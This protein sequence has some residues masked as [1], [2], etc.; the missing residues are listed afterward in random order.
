MFGLECAIFHEAIIL[1]LS[2]QLRLVLFTPDI[3]TII[4]SPVVEIDSSSDPNKITLYQEGN[5]KSCRFLY[6]RDET[7]DA[8]RN[9]VHLFARVL[10]AK[11]CAYVVDACCSDMFEACSRSC[12][13][14]LLRND[15]LNLRLQWSGQC[16]FATELMGGVC[17]WDGC[18]QSIHKLSKSTLY[19]FSSLASSVLPVIVSD[20][21]WTLPTTSDE[22]SRANKGLDAD[23]SVTMMNGNAILVSLL[24]G[25]IR[26]FTH[27]L[28]GENMKLQLPIVL[29][30]LLERASP[31][32]NHSVVQ[33]AA[34]ESLQEITL[35]IGCNDISSL[36]ASNFDYLVDAISLRLSKYTKE[37]ASME[38]SLAGVVDVI[39]QSIVYHGGPASDINNG[40]VSMI[41]HLLDCLLRH[42]DRQQYTTS[43]NAF[44]MARVFWSM[45]A[46][47]GSSID[48]YIH[49]NN[50]TLKTLEEEKTDDDWFQR[51]DIELNVESAAYYADEN[52]DKAFDEEKENFDDN[53]STDETPPA[54]TTDE[55]DETEF[56]QEIS[57]INSILSRCCYLLCYADLQIQVLCCGTIL[58]GFQSL[59]K[60]GSYRMKLR[61]EAANNPLLPSIAEYWP[62]II[63]RL[64]SAS[65]SLASVNKLSRSDLSIR[66][67]MA[68]DQVQGGPSKASLEVLISK[69]L[70]IV[71][72]LCVSSDGFFVDRF[73]KDVYPI[74][75]KL[76]QDILPRDGFN[77]MGLQS[78]K[79]KHSLTLPILS[80]FKSTFES[81]CRY[82][83]AG[84]IPSAGT[85]LFPFLS[86]EGP[87][88]DES[89]AAL[90]AMLAVDC[91]ALWRGLHTLSK[92]PF[93]D[94]P[95]H[96]S[97]EQAV[98]TI[99]LRPKGVTS[100]RSRDCNIILS[101]K[102]GELL[103]FIDQLPEQEI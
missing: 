38:R 72:E 20:P 81:S 100:V 63:A 53:N 89:M 93:P 12:S 54:G 22:R 95:I 40:N 39:L 30:P 86:F 76:I 18:K 70:L 24:M 68:T 25:F 62:P 15:A 84:L 98:T 58:S 6:I 36:L 46:F 34:F 78:A 92:R 28:G 50:A 97:G 102:A 33:R 5:I 44:D 60:I 71:S 17:G 59:G 45:D 4:C 41:S 85:M 31:V 8:A 27:I 16:V 48:S 94:K 77:G 75:S 43:L 67:M 56:M 49:K 73:E 103:D 26:Q 32:G 13:D 52:T 91:D 2:I 64:R 96:I 47:M 74:T 11:R 61:G 23:Q 88:G 87:I 66:H 21:L 14:M 80:C 51:L 10:G 7:V 79:Q 90:K 82:G 1:T 9:T 29:F 55:Q 3:D 65:A 83:L 42:F 19:I 99:E 37:Q 69:L 57:S 35:S 101:Q